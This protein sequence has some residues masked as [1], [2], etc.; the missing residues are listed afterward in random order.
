MARPQTERG[1]K[2]KAIPVRLDLPTFRKLK[3]EL[4]DRGIGLQALTECLIQEWLLFVAREDKEQQPL[5]FRKAT[6]HAYALMTLKRRRN[7]PPLA[8]G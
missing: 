4:A 2:N 6:D 8:L 7:E 3:K 5:D 1:P